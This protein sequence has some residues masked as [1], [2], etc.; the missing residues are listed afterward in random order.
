M[1]NLQAIQKQLEFYFSDANLS[2]DGFFKSELQSSADQSLSV[3]LLLN[4]NRL[5]LIGATAETVVAAAKRS[6][7]LEPV[8]NGSAIRRKTPITFTEARK[9]CMVLATGLSSWSSDP[10]SNRGTESIVDTAQTIPEDSGPSIDS[11][12]NQTASV[13]DWL[14]EQLRR[15]GPVN[16]VKLPRFKSSGVIR[17]FAFVEF[18]TQAS[19]EK[20]IAELGPT[21]TDLASQPPV[22]LDAGELDDSA[23]WTPK[24]A[25]NARMSIQDRLA[26][27][28]VWRCCS[29]RSKQAI[30]AYHR[31]QAAGYLL[32][33][34]LEAEYRT[35]T[36]HAKGVAD[37]S[38][39]VVNGDGDKLV[40]TL[41]LADV[42]LL[43][44]S[45]WLRWRPRFYTWLKAWINRMDQRS[46]QLLAAAD[47]KRLLAGNLSADS[48]IPSDPVSAAEGT[49]GS[50]EVTP[51]AS[52]GDLYSALPS[53]FVPGTVAEI[54]W[55]LERIVA[56]CQTMPAI[57]ITPL[58]T[59]PRQRM[60]RIRGCIERLFLQPH[61]LLHRVVH[62]D[63]SP[64]DDLL[65]KLPCQYTDADSYARCFVRFRDPES[66]A[67]FLEATKRVELVDRSPIPE[68]DTLAASPSKK[69]SFQMSFLLEGER[70][71]TYCMAIVAS[72]VGLR[73]RRRKMQARRRD[74][75]KAVAASASPG[76]VD[77][78]ASSDGRTLC[79][80][81]AAPKPTH[82]VFDE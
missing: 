42:R 7:I 57:A 50:E 61:D 24:M 75:Q 35:I 36:G 54:Y 34:P 49:S 78:A 37:E 55:P 30:A 29:R 69:S 19:A 82:I 66:A 46:K 53:D 59:D 73:E 40:K 71:R 18:S 6:R 33:N 72:R 20:A 26:R 56:G 76:K 32:P 17:G 51:E 3:N 27:Q 31:L 80:K 12:T 25:V 10:A 4:C 9:E 63:L 45:D 52:V 70:E 5:R 74:R 43:A 60:R 1:D 16:Y 48:S 8:R 38:D 41:S 11:V 47:R 22:P 58:D 15:Y 21:V 79:N 64:S 44:Y 81:A 68:A 2:R 65:A 39:S 62:F 77:A 13:V 14:S 28:F 23:A 67:V